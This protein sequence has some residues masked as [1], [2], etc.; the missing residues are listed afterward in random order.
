MTLILPTKAVNID[1]FILNFSKAR[2]SLSRVMIIK[3]RLTVKFDNYN[4]HRKEKK[5]R[6]ENISYTCLF[7]IVIKKKY[8]P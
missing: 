3:K 8:K 2:R 5:K 6:K 1:I 4:K 7:F